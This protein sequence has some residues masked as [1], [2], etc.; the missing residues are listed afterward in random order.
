MRARKLI[1]ILIIIIV[2]VEWDKATA[3]QS[4]KCKWGSCR[5]ASKCTAQLAVDGDLNTL[6]LTEYRATDAWWQCDMKHEYMVKKVE[7]Y[8]SSYA[9][10]QGA[11][12]H[13]QVN[14][15]LTLS[16]MSFSVFRTATTVSQ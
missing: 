13:L 9:Y 11:Y 14:I 8:L 12:K 6:S 7:L 3:K 4:E 1:K 10:R 2:Q 16:I 5:G 15:H